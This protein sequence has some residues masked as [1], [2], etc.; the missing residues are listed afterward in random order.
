MRLEAVLPEAASAE[1]LPPATPSSLKNGYGGD[2]LDL[3][4][5]VNVMLPHAA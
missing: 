3:G 5:A 1:A 4:Y 2:R